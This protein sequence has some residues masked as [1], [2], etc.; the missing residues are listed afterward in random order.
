[1][2]G[3][4]LITGPK[5]PILLGSYCASQDFKG[6]VCPHHGLGKQG[7]MEADEKGH[8]TNRLAICSIAIIAS[9]IIIQFITFESEN[10]SDGKWDCG[11][12]IVWKC[13]S[14]SL[15]LPCTLISTSFGYPGDGKKDTVAD[16]QAGITSPPYT[17]PPIP[18][19]PYNGHQLDPILNSRFRTSSGISPRVGVQH[20]P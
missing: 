5:C 2:K 3:G 18:K 15:L 11:Q 19:S 13:M 20:S 10:T 1:M 4:M 7:Y 8:I 17:S 6:L 9:D 16:D 12:E 14:P